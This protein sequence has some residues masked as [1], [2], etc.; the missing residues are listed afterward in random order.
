[1]TSIILKKSLHDKKIYYSYRKAEILSVMQPET[2]Y[3][4]PD[5]LPLLKNTNIPA[6]RYHLRHYRHLGLL[7]RDKVDPEAKG[8][9]AF[10][11]QITPKGKRI[12]AH[13]LNNEVQKRE[14]DKSIKKD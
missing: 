13:L 5:L 1:M 9:P 12:L 8:R 7:E 14:Q 2:Y 6:I 11:Y 3:T 10:K 4:A